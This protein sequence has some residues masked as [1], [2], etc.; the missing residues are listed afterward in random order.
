MINSNSETQRLIVNIKDE[1]IKHVNQTEILLE[2]SQKG[3]NEIILENICKVI[4]S[5]LNR[6]YEVLELIVKF[7]ICEDLYG[8]NEVMEELYNLINIRNLKRNL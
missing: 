2:M 3:T 7:E 6:Y 4:S 1:I 5:N 8:E